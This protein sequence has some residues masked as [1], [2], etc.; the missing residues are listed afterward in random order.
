ML[1]SY[2]GEKKTVHVYQYACYASSYDMD[3]IALHELYKQHSTNETL[4]FLVKGIS[5]K[6]Y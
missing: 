6:S 3:T 5:E 2:L 4:D 1:I